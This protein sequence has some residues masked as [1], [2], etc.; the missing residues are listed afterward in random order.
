MRINN[1]RNIKKL[2]YTQLNNSKNQFHS[3]SL[4]LSN[5]EFRLV[6]RSC[7]PFSSDKII[8]T[9]RHTFQYTAAAVDSHADPYQDY[10][11]LFNLNCALLAADF[12]TDIHWHPITQPGRHVSVLDKYVLEST[13]FA[14]DFSSTWMEKNAV[15]SLERK[16]AI[17]IFFARMR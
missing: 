6:C 1:N 16:H 4:K 12:P 11:K 17:G 9:E 13:H 15:C 14:C 5:F 3:W 2:Q 7:T 10:W 8:K